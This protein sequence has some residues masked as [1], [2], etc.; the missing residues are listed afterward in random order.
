[1]KGITIGS[2]VVGVYLGSIAKDAMKREG[3][4]EIPLRSLRFCGAGGF[5]AFAIL[6]KKIKYLT[7]S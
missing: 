4:N 6:P 7:C 5:A 3:T 1:M 2:P